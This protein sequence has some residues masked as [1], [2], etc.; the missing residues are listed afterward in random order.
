VI[1]I[2]VLADQEYTEFRKRREV[3]RSRL[4]AADGRTAM[5]ERPLSRGFL[6]WRLPDAGPSA[7]H[8]VDGRRPQPFTEADVCILSRKTTNHCDS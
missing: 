7:K 6:P 4:A 1:L 2:G 3:M 5:P 8:H